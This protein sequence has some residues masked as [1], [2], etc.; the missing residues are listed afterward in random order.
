MKR[1]FAV[2]LCLELLGACGGL[3]PGVPPVSVVTRR[4]RAEPHRVWEAARQVLGQQGYQIVQ[5]DRDAGIFETDWARMNPEYQASFWVTEQ[6]DRYSECAK[7][8][9]GQAFEGKEARLRLQL[10][11]SV[12]PDETA[13]AVQ[14]SFRTTLVRGGRTAVGQ[15]PP[16]VFCRST[17][18]LEDELAVRIQLVALGGRLDRLRRG[19]HR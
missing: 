5:E 8:R 2:V 19:G 15:A 6:Q 17:G 7:P 4:L 10:S 3:N 13:L 16:R 14:A 12:K 11:P 18:W 9:L 1:L